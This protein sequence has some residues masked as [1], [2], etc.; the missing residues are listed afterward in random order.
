MVNTLEYAK[1]ALTVAVLTLILAG[2]YIGIAKSPIDPVA[3]TLLTGMTLASGFGLFRF[4]FGV[5]DL[6]KHPTRLKNWNG[7]GYGPGGSNSEVSTGDWGSLERH[8]PVS[9]HH[10]VDCGGGDYGSDCGGG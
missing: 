4:L 8:T 10:F 9:H 1:K 5:V 7:I 3:T 6:L 2:C